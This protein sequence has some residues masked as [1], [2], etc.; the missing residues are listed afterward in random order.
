MNVVFPA[1]LICVHPVDVCDF[2]STTD[3]IR[4]NP[5]AHVQLY[6]VTTHFRGMHDIHIY[7]RKRQV[8]ACVVFLCDIL[9]ICI[10]S[11]FFPADICVVGEK[12]SAFLDFTWTR[13]DSYR[14]K[15]S[16][17]LQTIVYHL[18]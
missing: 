9:I 7:F 13:L 15:Y 10:H 3:P 1:W 8:S 5:L 16:A 12:C 11:I 4:L 18:A 6:R 2:H 17:L 14:H